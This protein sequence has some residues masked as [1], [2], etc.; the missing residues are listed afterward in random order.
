LFRIVLGVLLS[1]LASYAADPLV[2]AWEMNPAKS[3][4]HGKPARSFRETITPAGDGLSIRREVV[5]AAGKAI[6]RTYSYVFDGKSHVAEFEADA[7]HSH[8]AIRCERKA[9]GQIERVTDH[10]HGKATSM[11]R[12]TLSPDGKTITLVRSGSDDGTGKTYRE[13]LILERR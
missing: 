4:F 8:H 11:N 3:S 10:D 2:G 13:T 7:N 5:N 12:H 9:H 6:D 1:A